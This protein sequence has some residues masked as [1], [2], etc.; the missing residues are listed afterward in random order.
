MG[1]LE[2]GAGDYVVKPVEPRVLDA[3]IRA[4]LRRLARPGSPAETHGESAA[5]ETSLAPPAHIFV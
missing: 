4:V 5:P 3:R 2:A 1:G